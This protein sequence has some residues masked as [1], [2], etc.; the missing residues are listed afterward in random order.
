MHLTLIACQ[1]Q[2]QRP[3]EQQ[4]RRQSSTLTGRPMSYEPNLPPAAKPALHIATAT[5]PAH[6]PCLLTRF[7]SIGRN[8]HAL[9]PYRM[10]GPAAEARGAAAAQAVI[11]AHRAANAGAYPE[12]VAINLWGLDAIKTKVGVCVGGG[13]W[14][15]MVNPGG[16][17]E[18]VAT[19]L[20]G[21]DAVKQ[22]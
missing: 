22:V 5:V 2:Q 20:C 8:I 1:A 21:L 7:P 13:A 9:D 10:P 3:G 6:T 16:Y 15:L 18:T 17:P 19:N 11:D 12:T 4:Q 14:F